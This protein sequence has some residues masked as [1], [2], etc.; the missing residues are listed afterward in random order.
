MKR[1][2]KGI[3]CLEVGEW[4]DNMKART[5]VEPVLQLLRDSPSRV[6]YIHRD[7]AT[8]TELRFYLL[9]WLQGKHRDYPILYLGFHGSPG[10]IHLRK[11][12]GRTTEMDTDDLFAMLTG[13]CHRRLIHFG[14]CSVLDLHG[15]TV[16]RYLRDSGAIAISGFKHDVDWLESSIFEL[17]YLGELQENEF[18]R[19]GVAAVNR[20]IRTKAAG[21]CQR[22]GF[23]VKIKR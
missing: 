11:E 3:Y 2:R 8:E 12:N 10:R 1:R 13:R 9:K 18:T 20:R 19:S 15:H 14:S 17:L 16:N 21:F 22:L 23:S 5:S 7:I 6:P 4:F